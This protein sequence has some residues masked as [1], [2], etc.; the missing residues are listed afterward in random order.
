MSVVVVSLPQLKESHSHRSCAAVA[1]QK[2]SAPSPEA[3]HAT[4]LVA[5][6]V[7]HSQLL[8][9]RVV[10]FTE[11]ALELDDEQAV[12]ASTVATTTPTIP[13]ATIREVD[14]P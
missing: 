14:L 4:S 13:R 8:D 5:P 7:P 9:P 11:A 2:A 10:Q 3:V 12:S 6:A 1:L